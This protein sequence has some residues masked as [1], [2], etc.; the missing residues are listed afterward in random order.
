MSF[1]RDKTG[2]KKQM[3]LPKFKDLEIYFGCKRIVGKADVRQPKNI[4]KEWFVK[5]QYL[6]NGKYVRYRVKGGLNRFKTIESRFAE[7]RNLMEG[8]LYALNTGFNPS[9]NTFDGP[10]INPSVNDPGEAI[11]M[12]PIMEGLKWAYEKHAPEVEPKTSMDYRSVLKYIYLT[13]EKLKY[14]HLTV[15]EFRKA[16]LRLVM[17][18]I[19]K[20][21]GISDNRYNTFVE[22]MKGIYKVFVKYDAFD[23]SPI[24]NFERKTEPEPQSFETLTPDEKKKV[25]EYFTRENPNFLTYFLLVYHTALRPKELVG[26]QIYNYYETEECF[27]ISP[28]ESVI[29]Y[30]KRESKTKTKLTRYVP[31]PPEAMELLKA[32]N[33]SKYPKDYFIFSTEFTPGELNIPR[34]RATEIWKKHVIDTLKIDKKLYGVKHL[35]IDDKIDNDTSI[36]A[37]RQQAGHTT[38]QMTERYSK[39]IKLK[40]QKEI[41]KKSK[42]F[43]EE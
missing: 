42:G 30:G 24:A 4:K 9:G 28:T 7:A 34:K 37:I 6:V 36:D 40:N 14:N 32:M 41:N 17:G 20:D 12:M 3:L 26:L 23:V 2:Q 21:R 25:H 35:G 29:I 18:E 10:I 1:K 39:N 15:G 31:I 22:N 33:L 16:H 27:K 43:L 5:Y 13:I 11:R 19:Q 8:M 38:K